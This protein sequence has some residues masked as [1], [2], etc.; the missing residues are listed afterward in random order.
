MSQPAAKSIVF[1]RT[2]QIVLASEVTRADT[3]W[4]R[5]KGLVGTP[6]SEF[7]QGKGLWIVPCKGIHTLAMKYPIDAVYL[8][9]NN[10]VVHLEQ[11][12]GPWRFAPVKLRAA[13]VLE[14]PANTVA[15]TRTEVGDQ[16]EFQAGDEAKPRE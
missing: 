16:I 6:A 12:L 2:R 7:A 13:T 5:L 9:G 10:V 8:D 15:G 3:H 14:V 4:T 11:S 1:N